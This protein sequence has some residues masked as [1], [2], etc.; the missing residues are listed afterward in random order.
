MRLK[1]SFYRLLIWFIFLIGLWGLV[2]C[3]HQKP[4][5]DVV[6]R[7]IQVFNVAL[8]APADP[9]PIA[10]VPPRQEPC[11]S[12]YEF[13]YDDLDIV[14][15]F[16]RNDRVFRITTRNPKTSMFGIVPGDS[17]VQAKEKITAQGFQQSYT[18]YKFVRDWCLL[19]M[20]VNEKNTV[21]GITVEVLD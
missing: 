4:G 6:N 5:S 13:Y 1:K 18:P 3:A 12:G 7:Q 10:G 8:F 14:V 21:F 17:F 19:S 20:L 15:S 2:G 16:H 11:I 9:R